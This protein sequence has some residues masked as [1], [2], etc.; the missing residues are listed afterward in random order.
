MQ[1]IIFWTLLL[2]SPFSQAAVDPVIIEK[3]KQMT[4]AAVAE[5]K[6][7]AVQNI[8][9]AY[10]MEVVGQRLDNMLLRLSTMQNSLAYF[11]RM[12]RKLTIDVM[13]K[14][15]PEV[16][17]ACCPLNPGAL[18]GERWYFRG[19]GNKLKGKGLS[20][21][22]DKEKKDKNGKGKGRKRGRGKKGRAD[23]PSADV[24]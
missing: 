9:D 15:T 13:D 2:L 1:K 24:E 21:L 12:K 18:Q 8:R 11:S 23:G 4:R 6:K 20:G 16:A 3:V 17:R 19:K 10:L 14:I 7:S 5:E 22:R